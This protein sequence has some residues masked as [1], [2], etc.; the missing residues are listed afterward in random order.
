MGPHRTRCR[1]RSFARRDRNDELGAPA[2]LPRSR[3]QFDAGLGRSRAPCVS[4]RRFN[5]RAA[6]GND[7]RKSGLRQALREVI[8]NLTP[9]KETEAYWC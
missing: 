4:F 8:R 9:T 1:Q 5:G 2:Q 6:V 3:Y 7:A